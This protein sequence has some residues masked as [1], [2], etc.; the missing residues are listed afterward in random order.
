MKKPPIKNEKP[1]WSIIESTFGDA[2]N[3]N[4]SHNSHNSPNSNNSLNKLSKH[5]QHIFSQIFQA[6]G[7]VR[8]PSSEIRCRMAAAWIRIARLREVFLAWRLA[9]MSLC[10]GALKAELV[11]LRQ[12]AQKQVHSVGHM[13]KERLVEVAVAELDMSHQEANSHR[14]D[15]LRELIK[16]HRRIGQ[17]QDQETDLM[18]GLTRK[19]LAELQMLAHAKGI[20][21]TREDGRNKTRQMLMIELESR[22]KGVKENDEDFVMVGGPESH[23]ACTG[24]LQGSSPRPMAT[25]Q[26]LQLLTGVFQTSSPEVQLALN[27]VFAALPQAA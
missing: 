4:N 20:D 22:T 24:H 15:A 21:L 17:G 3:S 9:A 13:R 19:R 11:H 27:R 5:E 10:V 16:E 18:K 12:Y 2:S 14:A 26:D 8:A 7:G 23:S 1:E 25:P 6:A